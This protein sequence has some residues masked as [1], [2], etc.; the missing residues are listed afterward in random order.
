MV[1]FIISTWSQCVEL[2]KMSF[3]SFIST[4]MCVHV[5]AV[6]CSYLSRFKPSTKCQRGHEKCGVWFLQRTVENLKAEND[7]LKTGT[8]SPCPSPGPSSS[9]SQSSGLTALGGSSP[10]QSV[11]MHMPKSYSRGL[12]E[13]S[14]SGTVRPL[15]SV[16]DVEFKCLYRCGIF[17]WCCFMCTLCYVEFRIYTLLKCTRVKRVS[18]SVNLLFEQNNFSDL[19]SVFLPLSSSCTPTV[20]VHSAESL[21]LSA[22]RDDHRVRVVV[23]VADLHVFKDVGLLFVI[24][25]SSQ[26]SN[27]IKTPCVACLCFPFFFFYQPGC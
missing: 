9:V 15:S 18:W 16:L 27:L 6:V 7:Q 3:I 11:A 1:L 25:S 21:S 19:H 26:Q 17:P 2:V 23:C 8:L 4:L 22:Q 14:S 20:D 12:S 24:C 5:L 13:G 10:R